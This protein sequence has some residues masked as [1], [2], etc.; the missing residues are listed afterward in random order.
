M[1]R[2]I[3]VYLLAVSAVVCLSGCG[4]YRGQPLPPARYYYLTPDKDLATVGR[5]DIVEFINE[6]SNPQ[7]SD[8]IT[9]TVFQ[10]LQKEQIFGL[11]LFTL[12]DPE[13]KSLQVAPETGYSLEELQAMRDTLR[14]DA[15][16]TGTVA[17]YRPFPHMSVSLRLSMIDL[18]DGK[19]LWAVDHTWDTADKETQELIRRYFRNEVRGGYQPLMEDLVSI[20]PI[21]FNKFVAYEV[22]QTLDTGG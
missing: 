15:I 7:I 20:S 1:N 21:E 2:I 3:V 22:V 10:A 6:S 4:V 9:R 12:E 5:V 17:D 16:V 8:E 13:W 11:R 19:L 18:R 14:S